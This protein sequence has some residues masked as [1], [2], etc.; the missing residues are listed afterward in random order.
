M[1]TVLEVCILFSHQFTRNEPGV[2]GPLCDTLPTHG[3]NDMHGAD[4]TSTPGADRRLGA[5][6]T[7]PEEWSRIAILNLVG[8]GRFSGDRTTAEYA[9]DIW[10]V[11]P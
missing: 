2:F 10:K 4:L 5:S 3:D 6:D 7:D 8:L 11:E 9:P 1:E